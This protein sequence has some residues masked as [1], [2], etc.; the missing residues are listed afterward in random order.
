MKP[1]PTDSRDHRTVNSILSQPPGGSRNHLPF[2]R[3]PE[4]FSFP[5]FNASLCSQRPLSLHTSSCSKLFLGCLSLS[6]VATTFLDP[7]GWGG[8]RRRGKGRG[9]R[10]GG[11]GRRER[12]NEK[13]RGREQH[14]VWL[15]LGQAVGGSSRLKNTEFRH[16]RE[17]PLC[18]KS[19]AV[20]LGALGSSN[21]H[22]AFCL[23]PSCSLP[24]QSMLM[25][26]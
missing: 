7:L 9:R 23:V 17:S 3:Q 20:C 8:R 6:R 24:P 4:C 1:G 14:M 22:C 11:G 13:G 15:F 21:N 18:T 2:K 5:D 10:G 16:K 25:T 12:G 26:F 19:A